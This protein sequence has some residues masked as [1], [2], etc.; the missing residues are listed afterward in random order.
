MALGTDTMATHCNN[1]VTHE[2]QDIMKYQADHTVFTV[3]SRDTRPSGNSNWHTLRTFTTREAADQ[4]VIAQE[5]VFD[6]GSYE[7]DVQNVTVWS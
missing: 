7:Y 1:A 3:W 4:Y 5:S 6:Q 2:R